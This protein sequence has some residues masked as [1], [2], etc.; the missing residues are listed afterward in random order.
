MD[1]VLKNIKTLLESKNNEIIYNSIRTLWNIIEIK[2]DSLL[3]L[4]VL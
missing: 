2:E 1:I 4:K 3:F